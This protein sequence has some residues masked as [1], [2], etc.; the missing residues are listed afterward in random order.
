MTQ[1]YLKLQRAINN[2][3]IW[4]F[5]GSAGRAAVDAIAN[6]ECILGRD[7]HRDYWGN[8]VPS[9]TD[10]K[11]GTKGSVLFARNIQGDSYTRSIQRVK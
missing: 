11:S 6:G 7:G 10:V 5:E 1:H 4:L 9:R 3:S 8:Y 2:G